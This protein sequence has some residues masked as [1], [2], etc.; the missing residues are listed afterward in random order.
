MRCSRRSNEVPAAHRSSALTR[1]HSFSTPPAGLA[2]GRAD[3]WT[4][5]SAPLPQPSLRA[6]AMQRATIRCRSGCGADCGRCGR[7][8]TRDAERLP[9]GALLSSQVVRLLRVPCSQHRQR[10]PHP[11]LGALQA[12]C[13]EYE[14]PLHRQGQSVYRPPCPWRD[15]LSNSLTRQI[16]DLRHSQGHATVRT[17]SRQN[18]N[19][20]HRSRNLRVFALSIKTRV[21]SLTLQ[22]PDLPFPWRSSIPSERERLC[23]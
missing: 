15:N 10:R 8:R 18:P 19:R 21:D 17:N 14:Q 16:A 12:C 5:L 3:R 6:P 9:S 23:K 4:P 22:K 13:G 20:G 2:G 1:P 7:A 11:R